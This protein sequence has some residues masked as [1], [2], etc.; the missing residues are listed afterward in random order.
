M[1]IG[2][3][4]RTFAGAGLDGALDAVVESGIGTIQFNLA[5]AGVG[6]LPPAIPPRLAESV[7]GAV[8]RRGLEMVAVSGTYNMA[9]PDPA[10]RRAGAAALER[11]VIAAP[12]LGTRIV[13]ICTGTR[14]PHDMWRRHP[15]NGSA[16]AWADML[17]GV[18]AAVAVA[19]RHGVVVAFEPEPANVVDGA[20]AGRRLLDAIDSAH[21]GVVVDAANLVAPDPP[22]RHAATLERAFEVLGGD[23]VLAHAKDVA[24]DGA[25]VPA[26]RGWVDYPHYVSL[27]R[28]IGYDGCIVL[29][30]LEPSDV[31]TSVAFLAAQLRLAAEIG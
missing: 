28:A 3:F 31:P 6:S 21:L 24:A 23:V 26:G 19:E 10:V 7:R 17:E 12:A 20:E 4:A 30:G 11:L 2:I 13:T 18:E 1:R 29:H 25:F 27:L 15:D 16:S 8:E 22:D 5:L 9:H 14:D